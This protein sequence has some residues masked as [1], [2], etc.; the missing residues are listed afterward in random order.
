M[1]RRISVPLG[2]GWAKGSSNHGDGVVYGE[3]GEGKDV[4]DLRMEAEITIRASCE[5]LTCRQRCV[6][7]FVLRQFRVTGTKAGLVMMSSLSVRLALGIEYMEDEGEGTTEQWF[8]LFCSRCFSSKTSTKSMK[9]GSKNEN[10][11]VCAL[12]CLPFERGF[13]IR[14]WW[15]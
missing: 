7:W 8:G 14:R 1:P 2:R 9:R 6:G 13:L 5:V 4:R 3:V 11:V 12:R 15:Q 10:A